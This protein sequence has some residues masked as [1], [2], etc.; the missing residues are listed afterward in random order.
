MT[1]P[2]DFSGVDYA[3]HEE[4]GGP[5]PVAEFVMAQARHIAGLSG[6]VRQDNLWN[7]HGVTARELRNAGLHPAGSILLNLERIGAVLS[8]AIRKANAA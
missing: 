3:I 8:A 6:S 5:G 7:F 4:L 2:I 1:A